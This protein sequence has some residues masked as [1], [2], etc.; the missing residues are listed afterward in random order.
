MTILGTLDN[1]ADAMTKAIDSESIQ[2]HL[3]GID[4][5]PRNDRHH[6]TPTLEMESEWQEEE[7]ESKEQE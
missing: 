2:R 1:L 5:E 7:D 6:L 4:A 3:I